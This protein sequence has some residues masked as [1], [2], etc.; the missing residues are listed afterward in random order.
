[1]DAK[2]KVSIGY[3]FD[4]PELQEPKLPFPTCNLQA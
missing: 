4:A 1:M 2:F 3:L